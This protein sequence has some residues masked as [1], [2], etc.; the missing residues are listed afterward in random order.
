MRN[1][2]FSKKYRD[3][4]RN[5]ELARVRSQKV[6]EYDKII[7]EVFGPKASPTKADE[8]KI[9]KNQ[10]TTQVR[11]KQPYQNYL[12]FVREENLKHKMDSE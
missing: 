5:K 11:A 1:S 8:L 6:V 7:K 3:E 9:L 12:G 4:Q 2:G 10:L